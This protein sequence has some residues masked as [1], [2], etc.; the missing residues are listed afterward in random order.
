MYL[1]QQQSL[2]KC[3]FFIC[4]CLAH[5]NHAL[6][7]HNSLHTKCHASTP[8]PKLPP[9]GYTIP[10]FIYL[11]RRK[12][13]DLHLSQTPSSKQ[14]LTPSFI[15]SSIFSF[16]QLQFLLLHTKPVAYTSCHLLRLPISV[17]AFIVL[18]PLFDKFRGSKANTIAD[19]SIASMSAKG[20]ERGK[21]RSYPF[22]IA[23]LLEIELSSTLRTFATKVA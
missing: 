23:S 22:I 8:V 10:V 21:S 16:D 14:V 7:F 18:E 12:H 13:R 20:E 11:A 2:H 15:D 5:L 19:L 9:Q 4:H 1:W 17:F 6:R 3:L